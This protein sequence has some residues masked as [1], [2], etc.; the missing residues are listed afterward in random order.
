MRLNPFIYGILALSIFLGTIYIAK[1]NGFWSVSDRMQAGAEGGGGGGIG[2]MLPAGTDVE[3]IKGRMAL[4]DVAK[5]YNV[6][7][8]E[9]LEAF[10]LP[11]DTLPTQTLREL[12]SDTFSPDMLR[13]WLK[14]RTGQ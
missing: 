11:L 6:P 10:D 8:E 12:E 9:I 4:G 7:V 1:A 13:P 5:A 2:P 3:E 14:E